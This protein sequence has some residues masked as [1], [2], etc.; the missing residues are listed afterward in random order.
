[1]EKILPPG[2]LNDVLHAG[3]ETGASSAAF[4]LLA[5]LCRKVKVLH[6]VGQS[7]H[8]DSLFTSALR[9]VA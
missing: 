4:A 5:L 2:E 1:M 6:I 9:E 7:Q 3:I 8:N